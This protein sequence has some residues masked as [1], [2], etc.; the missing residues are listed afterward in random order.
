MIQFIDLRSN[1]DSDI[2]NKLASRSQFEYGDIQN[3]VSDIV[4]NV[5]TNGD[6]AVLEYTN[7]FDK[8]QLCPDNLMVTQIEIEEAYEKVD[9]ELVEVIKRARRI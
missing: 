1:K 3:K 2:F 8:V 9:K 4:N 7:M 6:K 5:K